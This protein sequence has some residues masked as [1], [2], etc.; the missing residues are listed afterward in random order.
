M[1]NAKSESMIRNALT[2]MAG[3]FSSRILGLLREVI[4]AACF[5]AG[6]SLDAFF[7]AYTIANLGRQL[8][9]EGALSAA[10]VPVFSQVLERSGRSRAERL[11]R[12]ALTVILCAGTCVVLLGILLSPQLIALIAPGF[13]GEKAELAVSLTRQMF[14]FLLMISAAALAMGVLN[15]MD[16]FLVPALAPALSNAVYI[17]TVVLTARRF[18]VESL[19]AAVLLGGAAQLLFQWWWAAYRKHVLLV[20]ARPDRNDPELRRMMALF[21]PYAAGLSLN[22][23]NPVLGRLFGSF[24]EDGAISMLNYSNRVIQLPLGLVVIAISQAVLPELSRCMNRGDDVFIATLRDALR[25]ALFVILPVTLGTMLVSSE[26]VNFLFYRGAFS[27]AAWQGTAS[28]LFYSALGLPGMACS[29]VVM[30]AL[31]ARSLPRQAMCMTGASVAGTLAFSAALVLPMRMNGIAL[32]SSLAFTFSSCVGIFMLRRSMAAPLKLI[33]AQWAVRTGVSCAAMWAAGA[34][35]KYFLPYPV[36]AALWLRGLWILGITVLCAAV[37]A[38]VSWKSGCE[39]WSLVF[40]AFHK[41]QN[42][43]R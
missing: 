9:A 23:L 30:R 38:A 19:V 40:A 8:L 21:L 39:E 7:V 20:P 10:F 11:A 18:G 12:E 36:S 33:T 28:T 37:Y 22:Q 2:M 26:S 32:A 13:S 43:Q 1:A 35:W 34:A 6:W 25:F 17:V 42:R 31:F 5:G 15:S 16:S 4:T 27:E 29:T 41:K 24:L 3:T 14:P